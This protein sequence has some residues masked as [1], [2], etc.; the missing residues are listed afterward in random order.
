MAELFGRES[1]LWTDL[2]FDVP[3]NKWAQGN[4]SNKRHD[5]PGNS[6]ETPRDPSQSFRRIWQH[7]RM[8]AGEAGAFSYLLCR[9]PAKRLIFEL[10]CQEKE[11]ADPAI[12]FLAQYVA[13]WLG[14]E[15][16]SGRKGEVFEH[17][18]ALGSGLYCT[19]LIEISLE[20]HEDV[21]VVL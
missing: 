14:K 21:V 12:F 7:C 3:C 17:G 4:V 10:N 5:S 6:P 2:T 20:V 18:L 19:G 1:L 11:A 15:V 9:L 16:S 8:F 13:W